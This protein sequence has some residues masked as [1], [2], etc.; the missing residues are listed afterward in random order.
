MPRLCFQTPNLRRFA[1]TPTSKTPAQT[2]HV[3]QNAWKQYLHLKTDSTH[4]TAI[5][6]MDFMHLRLRKCR[7]QPFMRLAE[8][9]GFSEAVDLAEGFVGG[10]L[11]CDGHFDFGPIAVISEAS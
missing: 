11:A 9:I 8:Q 2:I 1:Q 6:L 5:D 3:L 10:G 4:G 7:L